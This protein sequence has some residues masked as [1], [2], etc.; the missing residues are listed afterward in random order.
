M[1]LAKVI[2][3]KP[4]RSPS[5]TKSEP[6]ISSSLSVVI[7]TLNEEERLPLTLRSLP[8]GVDLIVIDS[9]STD[10]TVAL[11]KEFGARVES[12]N[13]EN[14]SSQKNFGLSLARSEWILSLD[15]DEVLSPQLGQEIK[16]LVLRNPPE[17]AFY[18]QRQL[19][20]LGRVLRFGKT[21]D[22]VLRLF[23]A[24]KANFK[25]EIHEKLSLVDGARMSSLPLAGTL[26][27]WSYS[28][29]SDYFAKFNKYTSLGAQFRFSRGKK[30]PSIL[31]LGCR[32]FA[33]FINRYFLRL[34]WLDG[35]PG[36]CF[37]LVSSLYGFMKYAKLIEL[38]V[39]NHK[40][41][42]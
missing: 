40:P 6:I 9:G 31:L 7:I 5:L 4:Q 22:K 3:R 25:G 18:L 24:G 11:A 16:N 41:S 26:M 27:H 28:S 38:K 10:Q 36:F 12:R 13:F 23:R 30:A 15:A 20:F 21:Q 19:V 8:S 32:P 2:C 1:I 39:K 14:Y 37:A 29:W 34:G 33:D 35:Y 17:D 42:E